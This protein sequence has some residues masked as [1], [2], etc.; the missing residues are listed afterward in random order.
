MRSENAYR[1]QEC[2]AH[3]K[4]DKK[5]DWEVR[6]LKFIE[7]TAADWTLIIITATSADLHNIWM[8]NTRKW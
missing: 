2:Q 6:E 4:M 5:M 8:D 3:A 1:Q 7:Q